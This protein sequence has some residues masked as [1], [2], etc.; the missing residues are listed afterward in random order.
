[1]RSLEKHL[2][3]SAKLIVICAPEATQSQY[4][5]DEIRQFARLKGPAGI[6]P[7]LCSGIPNNE[8]TPGQES[9]KAFPS[10]LCDLMAMPLAAD[11]R[12][13]VPKKNKING[14]VYR[15]AWYTTLA[16]IYDLPRAEIEER[17]KKRQQRLRRIAVSVTAV[18]VCLIAVAVTIAW[19]SRLEAQKEA[20]D[21]AQLQYIGNIVRAHQAYAAADLTGMRSL[22]QAVAP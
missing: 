6:I 4:V 8:A 16:N 19:R 7:V 10:A 3:D 2:T 21:A 18:I 15:D 17:D 22:L 5:N 11:F 13:F 12:G 1:H 14:G 20:R 9:Q